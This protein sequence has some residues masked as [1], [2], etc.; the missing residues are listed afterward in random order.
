MNVR[1]YFF[2]DIFEEVS[3]FAGRIIIAEK[4]V[5]LVKIRYD[6]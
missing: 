4:V 6:V 2:I 5:K 1:R 3:P